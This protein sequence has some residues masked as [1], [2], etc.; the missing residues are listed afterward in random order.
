MSKKARQYIGLLIAVVLYYVIHEGAHLVVALAL[1][2]FKQI[3]IIGL[4]VQIDVMS[5]QMTSQQMGIFCLAGPLATLLVGWAMVLCIRPIC[6]MRQAVLRA[7]AWYA[8]L[9]MLLLDPIYLSIYFRWVGGGDMNGIE[10]LVPQNVV[11]AIAAAVSVINT[12][13]IWKIVYP[14][15]AKSFAS[16]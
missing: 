4:G 9:V 12:L 14:A 6:T 16:N 11:V 1:G 13:L 15:Y 8:T 5:E 2:V 3:N 7:A 10:L